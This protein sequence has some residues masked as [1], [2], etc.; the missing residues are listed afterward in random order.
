MFEKLKDALNSFARN[1]KIDKKEVEKLIKEIQRA[2]ILS[3]VNVKIVFEITQTIK[4]RIFEKEKHEGLNLREHTIKVVYET[5]SEILGKE[6]GELKIEPQKILLVGL[7]GTGKTTTAAKLAYFFKKKGLKPCLITTDTYR[8]AAYEQ[9]KNLAEKIGVKFYGNK[10]ENNAVKILQEGLKECH[11]SE[12][13]IVDTAGRDA[14]NEELLNEI[15]ALYKVLEPEET[16]L[17]LSAD[18]GQAA[19]SLVESLKEKL[20]ITGIILTKMDSSAKGGGALTAAYLANIKVKFLGTGEKIE[21]LEYYDPVRF[22]S[23]LLGMGDL[24]TLLEKAREIIDKDQIEKLM[25]AKDY[26][27]YMFYEQLKATQKMGSLNKILEMIPGMSRMS[28]KKEEI[29]EQEIKIK[30]WGYI[31]DSMT[32]EERKNPKIIDSSRIKRIAKGSGTTEEDVREMLKA[33]KMSEKL[34]KKFKSGKFLKDPKLRKLMMNIGP[35]NA[36]IQEML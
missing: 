36:N 21:D 35:K 30:K 2:L 17:V 19:K 34:Y 26:D 6:K 4:K 8:P 5:L 25:E 15:N 32:V 9:L 28:F 3:D 16:L 29:E 1:K 31:F 27:M 18:I 23:R 12:V 14:F 13:I 7:Y 20:K 22:V 10:N 11:N 24:E 33:Y